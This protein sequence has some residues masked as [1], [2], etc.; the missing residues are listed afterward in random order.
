MRFMQTFC[1]ILLG[2]NL[3]YAQADNTKK[4]K[5][6]RTDHALTADQQGQS[7]NDLELTRKIRKSLTGDSSL[8]TYAKNIKIIS[9]EGKVLLRGPVNTAEEKTKVENFAATIA[10]A[11][12]VTSE[13]EVMK[14]DKE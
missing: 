1:T 12:K 14:H 3:A 8:S 7:E 6:D 9:R 10:G 2:I 11:A 13:I 5:R 4:N